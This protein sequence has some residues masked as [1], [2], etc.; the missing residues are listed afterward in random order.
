MKS[1][2][3]CLSTSLPTAGLTLYYVSGYEAYAIPLKHA[4]SL[5]I[6]VDWRT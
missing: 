3:E 1:T 5:Y 2:P 4:K 6:K